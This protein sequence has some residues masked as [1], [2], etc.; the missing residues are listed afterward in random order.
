VLNKERKGRGISGITKKKVRRG[1]GVKTHIFLRINCSRTQK[2][3]CRFVERIFKESYDVRTGLSSI[4]REEREEME[5]KNMHHVALSVFHSVG[6]NPHEYN[7][8]LD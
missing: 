4:K 6:I 2:Y 7:S 3:D 8:F 5:T 1:E